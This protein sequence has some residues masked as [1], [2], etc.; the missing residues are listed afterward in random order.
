M[1]NKDTWD[2]AHRY[3]GRLWL[4]GGL[5]LLPV[6]LVIM[7]FVLGKNEDIVGTVGGI[8][9]FFQTIPLIGAIFPTEKALIKEFDAEGRKR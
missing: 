7:L 6:S 5:I 3:F 4:K 2:F 9:C 1:K 8:L